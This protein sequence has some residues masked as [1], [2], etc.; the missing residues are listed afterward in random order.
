MILQLQQVFIIIIVHTTHTYYYN[1]YGCFLFFF[2][3][4]CLF[5]VVCSASEITLILLSL[6]LS[7]S[8]SFVCG[9]FFV[10]CRDAQHLLRSHTRSFGRSLSLH[11]VLRYT[12]CDEHTMRH[13]NRICANLFGIASAAVCVQIHGRIELLCV[14]VP[15][16]YN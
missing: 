16:G 3:L 11:F 13:S 8:T 15:F 5:V 4:L 9:F 2:S 7:L 6:T 12:L 10:R 14:R 1:T